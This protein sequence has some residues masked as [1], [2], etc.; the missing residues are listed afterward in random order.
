MTAFWA[1]SLLLAAARARDRL[2]AGDPVHPDAG[3]HLGLRRGRRNLLGSGQVIAE[4]RRRAI[5]SC[6]RLPE[7]RPAASAESRR[8]GLLGTATAVERD[9]RSLRP[10]R[11]PPA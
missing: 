8:A 7:A 4:R 11:R 2:L 5:G 3:L 9:P 6:F 10:R 1:A